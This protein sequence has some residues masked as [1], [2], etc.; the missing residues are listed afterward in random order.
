MKSFHTAHKLTLTK[1]LKA[2]CVCE[3]VRVCVCVHE[4]V[5]GPFA[6]RTAHLA[7]ANGVYWCRAAGLNEKPLAGDQYY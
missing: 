3:C 1:R 5:S 2:L 6:F 4:C 7:Y